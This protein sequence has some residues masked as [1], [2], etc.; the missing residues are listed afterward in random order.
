LS[1]YKNSLHQPIEAWLSGDNFDPEGKQ[2]SSISE[3]M[4]IA[5]DS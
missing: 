5:L 2:Y 3:M 4:R 1:K